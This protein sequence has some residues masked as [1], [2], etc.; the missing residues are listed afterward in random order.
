MSRQASEH[1][2]TDSGLSA[3]VRD[4]FVAEVVSGRSFAEVGGLWGTVNEKVSVA[5]R[6]GAKSL[7]MIDVLPP[8]DPWWQR[9]EERMANAGISGVECISADATTAI[10]GPF[11]V[12]H[13]SGVLYHVP[14]P[15][16]FLARLRDRLWEHLVLTSAVMPLRIENRHGVRSVPEGGVLSVAAM[17]ARDKAHLHRN[18]ILAGRVGRSDVGH[19]PRVPPFQA[20]QLRPVMVAAHRF[21]RPGARA[22]RRIR[23]DQGR[24]ALGRYR[25]HLSVAQALSPR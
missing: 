17:S 12:V 23:A 7:T 20:G 6:A 16:T 4:D 9:F 24:P 13:C 5:A 21:G 14:C 2:A 10:V 19:Q 18:R 11:D 15:I 25:R 1:P 3:D 22:P 8:G